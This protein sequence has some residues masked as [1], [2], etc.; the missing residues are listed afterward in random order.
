MQRI[1]KH[2]AI[3]FFIV[4]VALV[5]IDALLQALAQVSIP[6]ASGVIELIP[7]VFYAGMRFSEQNDALP[8]SRQL[9]RIALELSL[10]A[11]VISLF[12]AGALMLAFSGSEEMSEIDW[13]FT[14][15]PVGLLVVALMFGVLLYT[16][17]TRFTLPMAMRSGLK[18][19]KR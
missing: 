14:E 17:V 3:T 11:L 16:L 15:V 6:N 10:I 12:I 8:N 1:H 19:R 13:F 2:F 9:W 4:A 5:V 7:A 18:T